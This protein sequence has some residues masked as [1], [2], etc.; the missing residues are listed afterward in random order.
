MLLAQ[1]KDLDEREMLKVLRAREKSEDGE[2]EWT[3]KSKDVWLGLVEYR[4][5]NKVDV[6]RRHRRAEEIQCQI[7]GRRTLVSQRGTV[8]LQPGDFVSIPMGVA[9]KDVVNEQSSHLVVLTRFPAEPKGPV[10][11]T[12]A[13]TEW[14]KVRGF[15]DGS[16]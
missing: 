12:A 8:D 14:Q 2:Y 10:V 15:K 6:Y 1:A 4:A 11:K 9:F 5:R 13:P 3:Y 7:R 16:V